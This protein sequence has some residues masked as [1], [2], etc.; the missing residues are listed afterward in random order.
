VVCSSILKFHPIAFISTL[1]T[2]R[3][4]FAGLNHSSRSPSGRFLAG[5][6]WQKEKQ[7]PSFVMSR[8]ETSVGC[9]AKGS[10]WFH[11]KHFEFLPAGSSR[12]RNDKRKN[13]NPF[14]AMPTEGASV[15]CLAKGRKW[16]HIKHFEFL[17][18][19]SSRVRNDKRKNKNPSFV[20]S[21]EE[22]SVGCLAKVCKQANINY[23]EFPPRLKPRY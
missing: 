18:A 22:A 20:M 1:P 12:A 2:T 14:F 13:K 9:L 19:D 6:E 16:F 17:P 4:L 15:G 8:N 11:I 5:P 7:N 3:W 21:T 10:K 23:F